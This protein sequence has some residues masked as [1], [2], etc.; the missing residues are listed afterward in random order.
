MG[1]V[2][3]NQLPET[4]FCPKN[5]S[6]EQSE[7]RHAIMINC[8]LETVGVPTCAATLLLHAYIITWS[9]MPLPRPRPLLFSHLHQVHQSKTQSIV[10]S[11]SSV[12]ESSPESR[13]QLLHKDPWSTENTRKR[14]QAPLPIFQLCPHLLNPSTTDDA[15]GV[16]RFWPHVISCRNS[17]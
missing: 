12:H 4:W 14:C 17:F 6:R 8:A 9:K 7:H 11:T 1:F 5:C 15:F 2:I 3:E 16:V 13:V 10:Q